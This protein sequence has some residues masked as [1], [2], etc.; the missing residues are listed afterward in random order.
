MYHV[1]HRTW[2]KVNPAWPG[3]L[4]PHPGTK[5]TIAFVDEELEARDLCQEY[6]ETHEPGKLSDKAEYERVTRVG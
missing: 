2:W 4:E 6:N 1:F 3:G 5:Y